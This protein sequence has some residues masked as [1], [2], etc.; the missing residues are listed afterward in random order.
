MKICSKC[1][2]EKPFTDFAK[3]SKNK[4]GLRAYC[5][6][7]CKIM[8]DKYYAENNE[9]V[10]EINRK[11]KINNTKRNKEINATNRLIFRSNPANA[12]T[13]KK[14]KKTYREKYP[15]KSYAD[16]QKRRAMQ[17]RA[18]PKFADKQI[19]EKI[20]KYA[21]QLNNQGFNI[22]VDHIVPLSGRTVSGLHVE[23]NLQ[24]ISAKENLTKNNALLDPFVPSV[25]EDTKFKEFML[26]S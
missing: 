16:K 5:K 14:Y 1:S 12:S 26:L 13:I 10:K 15:E 11:W 18:Y 25:L 4:S 17:K 2:I 23:W 20:Y 21:K 22:H 6:S 19:L 24:I 3:D 7:C 8:R 9:K